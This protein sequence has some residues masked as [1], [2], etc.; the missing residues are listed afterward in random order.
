MPTLNSKLCQGPCLPYC[1]GRTTKIILLI[2]IVVL[3][4]VVIIL[5]MRLYDLD[6]NLN[7]TQLRRNNQEKNRIN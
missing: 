1:S 7:R 6:L 4:L 5:G 2:L 3:S